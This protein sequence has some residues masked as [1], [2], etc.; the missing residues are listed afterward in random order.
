MLQFMGSNERPNNKHIKDNFHIKRPPVAKTSVGAEA[1]KACFRE[2]DLSVNR[3]TGQH[4]FPL[5]HP[6][7]SSQTDTHRCC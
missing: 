2:P 7:S 5:H 6:S 4:L 1:E 3:L